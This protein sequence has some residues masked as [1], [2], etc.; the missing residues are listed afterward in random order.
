MF[1]FG[2]HKCRLFCDVQ[3]EDEFNDDEEDEEEEEIEEDLV[4]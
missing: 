4:A 2:V 1:S 3:R